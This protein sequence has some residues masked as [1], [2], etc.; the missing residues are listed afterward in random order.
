[1]G[2]GVGLKP[3][4]HTESAV[5]KS[6]A[7]HDVPHQQSDDQGIIHGPAVL[8]ARQTHLG[9]LVLIGKRPAGVEVERQRQHQHHKDIVRRH[10]NGVGVESIRRSSVQF[11]AKPR[12]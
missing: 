3:R 8:L 2:E 10:H 5:P 1:M 11:A 4:I 7:L 12:G 6:T 9:G